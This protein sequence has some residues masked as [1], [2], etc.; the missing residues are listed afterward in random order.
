M[1][2]ICSKC[3]IKKAID[4]FSADKNTKSGVRSQCKK[5]I[6]E[7]YI[8]NKEKVLLNQKEKYNPLKKKEYYLKNI[9]EHTK[10]NKEYYEEKKD[11]ILLRKKINYNKDAKKNYYLKNKYKINKLASKRISIKRHTDSVFK[12]KHNI[13]CLIRNSIKKKGY[14]KSKKTEDIIG[15]SVNELLIHLSSMFLEGM[16]FDNHGDWHIDH[17]I[18]LVTAKTEDEVIKLNHYTNLQ[19][20]WAKDNLSK[21]GNY[22]ETFKSE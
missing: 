5:C 21:S 6:S 19:P 3:K 22:N 13:S 8:L 15:C 12:L 9:N 16:S 7:R 2:K 10:R 4:E 14:T 11:K 1:K 20:L 18:P 17:I